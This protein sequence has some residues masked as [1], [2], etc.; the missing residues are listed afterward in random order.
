MKPGQPCTIYEEIGKLIARE[1]SL[2]ARIDRARRKHRA[3][4][5]LLRALRLAKV[6]ELAA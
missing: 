5:H 4:R 3:R 2:A 1:F 6:K